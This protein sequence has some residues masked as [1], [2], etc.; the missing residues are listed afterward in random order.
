MAGFA[1]GPR[2]KGLTESQNKALKRFPVGR[3]AAMT[4]H[5]NAKTRSVKHNS[6]MIK[7]MK[8]GKSIPEAH[9][10]AVRKVG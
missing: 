10:S 4:R 1:S 9:D 3:R 6:F 2:K 7:E 5:A 8:K